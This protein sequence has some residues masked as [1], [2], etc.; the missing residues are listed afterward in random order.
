MMDS[1]KDFFSTVGFMPHGSCLSWKP[2]VLW[3]QVISDAVITLSYFVIPIAIIVIILRRNDLKFKW[4]FALFGGFIV[5]C[6]ATHMVA[7]IAFWIPI[8]GIQATVK[9]VTATISLIT[10]IAIWPLIP[11]ILKIPSIDE[12]NKTNLRLRSLNEQLIRSKSYN[13][14]LLS[15]AGEGIYGLNKD[16]EVTF[17]NKAALQLLGF[18]HDEIIGQVMHKLTHYAYPDGT[19]YPREKCHMYAAYKDGK[20]RKI[21]NEV[22]WRK[23]GSCFACEY[24]STPIFINKETEGAVVI[25]KDISERKADEN[26]LIAMTQ[27]LQKTNDSLDEFAYIV[28]HDLKE[29]LRGINSYIS[30]LLEDYG[31]SLEEDAVKRLHKLEDLSNKMTRLIETLLRY[32]RVSRT[33]LDIQLNSLSDVV[34]EKVDL[35]ESFLQEN[36]AEVIIDKDIPD[37]MFDKTLISELMQNLITNAV[38]YNNSE[39]KK[40]RIFS[41]HQDDGLVISVQDNGIGIDEQQKTEIFKLFKR[42]HTADKYQG[43]SGAGLTFV[44]KIAE[45]HQAT[46]WVGSDGQSGS[47]FNFKFPDNT[48][49]E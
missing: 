18:S 14:L 44:K 33:A 45:M 15:S 6:G 32:S 1:I 37:F 26:Q 7:M 31:E 35:L 41:K 23:D 30:F 43:G 19:E 4:L 42:L 36:S 28:S 48:T 10:A 39:Q 29:P 47:I 40:I 11:K 8:Y 2:A 20:A 22:L 34:K 9:A 46:F 49:K 5:S 25:F 21:D 13:D 38:K 16:G 27:S 17:I 24:T 12:L 3:T